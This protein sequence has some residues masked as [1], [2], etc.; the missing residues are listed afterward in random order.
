VREQSFSYKKFLMLMIGLVIAI[1]IDISVFKIYD[2]TDKYL[3][4]IQSKI[5][6]FSVNSSLC[7]LFQYFIIKYVRTAFKRGTN[8]LSEAFKV[9]V[10]YVISLI[11]LSALAVFIGFLIF[12]Q[13]YYNYHDTFISIFIIAI[14]Y[15]T[16]VTFIIWLSM[17]F[18]SW[19]K[20]NHSLIVFLY[21]M[22]MLVIAFNLIMTAVYSGAKVND[23]PDRIREFVGA[24][25]D[26]YSGRHILLDYIY[27]VSS[28]MS[29]FSIWITTAILM[30]YYREKLIYAL[31]YWIM[32]T[33]PLVYFFISYFYQFFLGNLLTSYAQIDPVTSSIVLGAFLSLSKPIGGLIFGAAFWNISRIISYERNI[34]TYMII[35]GW[36]LF[37]IFGTNQATT[38]IVPAFPAFGLATLTVLNIAAYLMLLG[39]YN[40]ARLVSANNELRR[41][42]HKHALESKLLGLIGHAEMENEIQK[43]VKQV[44]KDKYDLEKELKEPV[45]LDEKE[46]EKYIEFVVREVKKEQQDQGS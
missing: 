2:L 24:S 9:R 23:L 32:L 44:T 6:L 38:Q 28:F 29:F 8:P 21:F 30:N 12:Q 22:S 17:L 43:T 45:E 5:I 19:Y 39:I 42:I 34:K 10:F 1:L 11:S 3:I 18:L 35:S 37:L 20:S 7:L 14:S 13:I 40:S 27:R 46:L 25:G 15:G 31:A 26:F 4:P 33:V 36:G 16:A 41:S